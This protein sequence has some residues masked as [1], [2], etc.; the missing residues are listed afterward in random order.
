MSG[1]DKLRN[2]LGATV[3]KSLLVGLPLFFETLTAK[4]A[5]L[6][7]NAADARGFTTELGVSKDSTVRAFTDELATFARGAERTDGV[8]AIHGA[9]VAGPGGPLARLVKALRLSIKEGGALHRGAKHAGMHLR[10]SLSGDRAVVMERMLE[11]AEKQKHSILLI[12]DDAA[13]KLAEK[14]IDKLDELS[15]TLTGTKLDDFPLDKPFALS[16]GSTVTRTKFWGS[17]EKLTVTIPASELGITREM[18]SVFDGKAYKAAVELAKKQSRDPKLV[19]PSTFCE[20]AKSVDNLTYVFFG[21]LSTGSKL[22]NGLLTMYPNAQRLAIGAAVLTTASGTVKAESA[23]LPGAPSVE[24]RVEQLTA[25]HVARFAAGAGLTEQIDITSTWD[26]V[27]DAGTELGLGLAL[28]WGIVEALGARVGGVV[29]FLLMPTPLNSG[30]GATL[31][32]MREQFALDQL[33]KNVDQIAD[34]M[35]GDITDRL[36]EE[37]GAAGYKKGCEFGDE[38]RKDVRAAVLENLNVLLAR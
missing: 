8:A 14:G 9:E 36:A 4:A 17:S 10:S 37:L 38:I 13:A 31:A 19:D 15:K 27:K 5:A 23:K 12:T 26:K 20:P 6:P 24:R 33:R 35:T 29:T 30:E 7:T 25:E 16:G 21:E 11:V 22:V 3:P 18:V 1:L 34:A 32:M 28:D 2:T